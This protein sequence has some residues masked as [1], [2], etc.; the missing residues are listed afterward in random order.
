MSEQVLLHTPLCD[1]HTSRGARMVDFASWSMPVQYNSVIEE[2]NAVR[3]GVGVTDVSH[4][5][6]FLF[7][8]TENNSEDVAN[9]LGSVVTRRIPDMPLGAVRYS[10]LTNERGG[11]IDDLVVGHFAKNDGTPFFFVVVNA[12]NRERDAAIFRQKLPRGITM[13]D[14]TLETAMLAIQGPKSEELLTRV[15]PNYPLAEMKYYRGHFVERCPLFG[16]GEVIVS[17]TGYTGDDGFE[18]VMHAA[19]AVPFVEKLFAASH[20]DNDLGVMP[21]GLG[22]RDTLRLEA[23][24]PLYGHELSEEINPFAAGLN[25]ALY[26]TG[27]DFPGR[28]ALIELEKSLQEKIPGEKVR[29]G[30]TLE[31]KRPAR[32]GATILHNGQQIGIVTSGTFAPTLQIPIAMGYVPSDYA[33]IGT[34]LEIDI[35]GTRARA[36]VA[37]MPF[38]KRK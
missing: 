25:R 16:D 14:Q 22:A 26:L 1:W 31:G 20:S 35:R 15:L 19:Q 17:R 10:L 33:A 27:L 8:G 23:A 34:E 5:G 29:I 9:Y 3:R 13:I 21:V 37:E 2:H 30:L 12:S 38:Y 24:M 28:A 11:I 4:M 36:K 6:R 32:E 7:F 18:I